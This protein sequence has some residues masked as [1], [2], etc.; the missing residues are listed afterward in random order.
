MFI[1]IKT[2]IRN[3]KGLSLV[4]LLAVIVILG[5]VASIATPAIG[6]IVQKSRDR[7]IIVDA[8]SI[9]AV[10]KMAYLDSS[11]DGTE[12]NP[13]DENSLQPYV[14]GIT[15]PKGTLVTYNRETNVWGIIYPAF[16][17]IKTPSLKMVATNS[18]AEKDLLERLN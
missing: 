13:C 17:D 12:T 3:E 1:W 7:A 8:T 14:D 5:I 2:Q 6:D 15:L 9:I 4:E 18:I 11:C 10:A 16:A